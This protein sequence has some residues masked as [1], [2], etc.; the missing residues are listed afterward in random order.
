MLGEIRL[1][2]DHYWQ[3]LALKDSPREAYPLERRNPSKVKEAPSI[4]RACQQSAS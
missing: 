4:D 1:K 3:F 2:R